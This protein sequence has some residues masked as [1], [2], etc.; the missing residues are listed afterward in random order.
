MIASIIVDVANRQVNRAFDYLVPESLV[1]FIE[2]GYR[3]K[4]PFGHQDRLGFVV[5]LKNETTYENSKLKYIKT[6]LE[7]SP[8]LN[9][10]FV[11]LA[12]YMAE[13]YYCFYIDTLKTMIPTALNAKYSKYII[14]KDEN[15]I[16]NSIKEL[17]INNK[18]IL[19]DSI[20]ASHLKDI[21]KGIKNGG[22]TLFTEVKNKMKAKTKTMISIADSSLEFRSKKGKEMILFLEE[23]KSAVSEKDLV[24]NEGYSKYTINNLV[25]KGV[26][27]KSYINDYRKISSFT[28]IVKKDIVLNDAQSTAFNSV[29][30]SQ[31]DT[32][33]LH[34]VTGSGKTEVYLKL[35]EYYLNKGKEAIMLVPEIS[36][37][38]QMVSRLIGKFGEKVAVLHSG[39]SAGEK[40]DEWRKIYQ[41]KVKIVVGARSA[42]F[43]PFNNLGIIIIDESHDQSYI[44]SNTPRYDTF[45]IASVRAK[46]HNC[47]LLLGTATPLVKRYYKALKGEIKLLELKTRANNFVLPKAKVIDMK[48][49]LISGNRSVFSKELKH[50]INERLLKNEQ[51]I[52]FLNKRG[53]STFVQCRE[54]GEA[55]TCPNCDTTL[56]YHQNKN[57]L[58]C[59]Y[60]GFKK[61]NVRTCP[62]CGSTKIK[63]VGTGTEKIVDE[64]TKIW[65]E[66]RVIRIDSDNTTKKNSTE[67]FLESF[68]N[69]EADILV[70]TQIIAKGLD[71]PLVTLVGVLNADLTMKLPFFDAYERTYE[72]LEQVSGRTGRGELGGQILIQTYNP[73]HY[74][75]RYSSTHDYLGFYNEELKN[76]YISDNPPF[77]ENVEI[78]CTGR[79]PSVLYNK[80][81]EVIKYIKNNSSAKVLGPTEDYIFRIN[82]IY[83]F[84]ISIKFDVNDLKSILNYLNLHYQNNKDIKLQI[85]RS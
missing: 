46:T 69:H 20:S 15:L 22:L 35:I 64:I 19:F 80:A 75:V 21:K 40:Y 65:P 83:R 32:F 14:L 62:N 6:F 43:A 28:K 3:V 49:E 24:I 54:C 13:E 60:C 76:R 26:L 4:V 1:D 44:Q 18:K 82:N 74:T 52:L 57:Q 45:D 53:H 30:D 85:K 27:K 5:D 68:R 48:S 61:T 58:V 39:L 7:A 31:N 84:K 66:A 71:Y 33:L 67:K 63:F 10:E 8:S 37:T 77:K 29:I 79:D 16:E 12:Y 78:I 23:A 51:T 73:K 11:E 36:L 2:I 9:K 34:G 25:K 17:F 59:H 55:V 56:T 41:N 70:G 38:P 50:M 81:V 72:L 47:N 42:I